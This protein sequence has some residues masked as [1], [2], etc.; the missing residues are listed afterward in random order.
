MSAT[1][2][3]TKI[4]PR[5]VQCVEDIVNSNGKGLTGDKEVFKDLVRGCV[6]IAFVTLY[7]GGLFFIGGQGGSG[8]VLKKLKDPN[9]PNGYKWSGPVSVQM[10]GLEGG[11]IFGVEKISSIIIFNSESALDAFAGNGQLQLGVSA[12]LAIGPFG[13]DIAASIGVGDTGGVAPAISWSTAKGGYVGGVIDGT[14]WKVNN[15]EVM[16]LYGQ[17]VNAKDVFDGGLNLPTP[18]SAEPL[19]QALECLCAA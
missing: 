16:A 1:K 5:A 6:G 18:K 12:S 15:D 2:L 7:K 11:F 13:R 3:E 8:C 19:V 9:A 14:A 17:T 4:I 10:G